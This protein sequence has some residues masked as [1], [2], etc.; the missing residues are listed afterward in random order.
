VQGKRSPQTKWQ[1]TN[2]R[3]KKRQLRALLLKK[4]R[5]RRLLL[6]EPVPLRKPRLKELRQPL[7]LRELQLWLQ[8]KPSCHLFRLQPLPQCRHRRSKTVRFDSLG[9]PLRALQAVNK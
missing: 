5:P 2:W 4:Q 9:Y 3:L 1:L 6:K 8:K 7:L